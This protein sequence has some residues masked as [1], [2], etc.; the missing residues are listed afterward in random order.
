MFLYCVYFINYWGC[1]FCCVW[2][3]FYLLNNIDTVSCNSCYSNFH[4]N[5]KILSAIICISNAFLVLV[6]VLKN[7]EFNLYQKIICIIIS[8]CF[9]FL[10]YT[11]PQFVNFTSIYTVS[12]GSGMGI[13]IIQLD[14]QSRYV[15]LHR[16][17]CLLF[18]VLFVCS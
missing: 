14:I 8:L 6:S 10:P 4:F 18:L 12:L 3:Y 5:Y 1:L 13:K 7:I 15:S 2:Q 9:L 17:K 11:L 16:I